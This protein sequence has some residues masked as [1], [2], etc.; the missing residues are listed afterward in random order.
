MSEVHWYAPDIERRV[1]DKMRPTNSRQY[2][3]KAKAL[4]LSGLSVEAAMDIV[5]LGMV[6]DFEDGC[7][8][9]VRQECN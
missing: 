1:A 4:I 2:V 3:N 5:L 7:D 6:A 9:I 8:E